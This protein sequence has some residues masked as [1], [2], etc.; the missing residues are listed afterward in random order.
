VA[1]HDVP[2]VL[3]YQLGRGYSKIVQ[4]YEAVHLRTT[5]LLS[6]DVQQNNLQANVYLFSTPWF[7]KRS[8]VIQ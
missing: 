6:V 1:S 5:A 3:S 2:L 4:E 8:K 7:S